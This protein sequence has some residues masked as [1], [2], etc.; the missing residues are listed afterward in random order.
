MVINESLGLLYSLFTSQSLNS[1]VC[2]GLSRR[3]VSDDHLRLTEL[4]QLQ[5]LRQAHHAPAHD[6]DD[7]D[8][9]T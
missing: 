9:G 8:Y 5:A 4:Y 7:H 6:D 1:R 3:R 2:E